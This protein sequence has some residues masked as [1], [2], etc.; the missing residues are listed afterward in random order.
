M[1]DRRAESRYLCADMVR[2]D[3]LVGEDELVSMEAVLEDISGP[4]GCVQ[5]EEPVPLGSTVTLSIG[6]ACFSGQV[7]YCTYRDYGYFVGIQFGSSTQWSTDRVVPQHLTNLAGIAEEACGSHRDASPGE[8][9]R[10]REAVK[11]VGG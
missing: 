6:E 9:V 4:G 2:L 3:Y 7:C 8:L 5:V 11:H 1:M 10:K